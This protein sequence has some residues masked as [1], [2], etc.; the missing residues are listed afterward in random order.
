MPRDN[1]K[2][3]GAPRRPRIQ[4]SAETREAMGAAQIKLVVAQTRLR[5][6][7]IEQRERS[8]VDRARAERAGEVFARRARDSWLRWP[9][10]VAP[11]LATRWKLDTADVADA[12]ADLVRTHLDELADATLTIGDGAPRSG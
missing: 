6:L 2:A 10:R 3:L 1:P 4:A 5:E 11:L 12:L 8:L 7:D 9:A